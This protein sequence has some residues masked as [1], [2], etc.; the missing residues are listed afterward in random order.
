MNLWGLGIGDWAQSPNFVKSN[1]RE[2]NQ[3]LNN[4]RTRNKIQRKNISFNEENKTKKKKL[5]KNINSLNNIEP[6]YLPQINEFD[7]KTPKI[8]KK[9]IKKIL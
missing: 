7:S 2:I 1:K 3:N 9:I 8:L 6:A 5:K 4:M